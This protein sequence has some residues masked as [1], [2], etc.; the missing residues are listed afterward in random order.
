MILLQGLALPGKTVLWWNLV[1]HLVGSY[2]TLLS[3]F[4]LCVQT[5]Q[6]SQ[7]LSSVSEML[8]EDKPKKAS[9]QTLRSRK[10]DRT[11][12]RVVVNI[13]KSELEMLR[14]SNAATGA[15]APLARFTIEN[16]WVAFRYGTSSL[17]S[18]E[19]M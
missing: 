1:E 15:L 19:F 17:V 16:L 2:L 7:A 5:E 18:C 12:L 6:P 3:Q 4:W 9:S 10:Q 14:T 11:T 8:V 13:G